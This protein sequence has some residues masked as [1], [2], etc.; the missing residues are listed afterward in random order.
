MIPDPLGDLGLPESELTR[1]IAWDIGIAGVAERISGALDP[2]LIAQ[3]YSQLVIDC[4]RH[5]MSRARFR[6]SV[7]P[8]SSGQRGNFTI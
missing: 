2:H 1:H 5:L 4:N 6:H 8:R 7:K 3:R